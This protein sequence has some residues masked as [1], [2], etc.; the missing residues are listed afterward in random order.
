MDAQNTCTDKID[1]KLILNWIHFWLRLEMILDD[2]NI[3][4]NPNWLGVELLRNK[5][6][7]IWRTKEVHIWESFNTF[8]GVLLC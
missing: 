3:N 7:Y 5:R 6:V 4:M 8:F 2:Y 1:K